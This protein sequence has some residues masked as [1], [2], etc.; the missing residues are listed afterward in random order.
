M[1]N[2]S[3]SRTTNLLG[4]FDLQFWGKTH[5]DLIDEKE[6]RGGFLSFSE[7]SFTVDAPVYDN[8][9][10]AAY[11]NTKGNYKS[12][13]TVPADDTLISLGTLTYQNDTLENDFASDARHGANFNLTLNNS[14]EGS[15]NSN[16][17]IHI[18]NNRNG[19]ENIRIGGKPGV[20]KRL[21]LRDPNR[22]PLPIF[23]D[24]VG[25][26]EI[27]ASEDTPLK[28]S[29]DVL[30]STTTQFQL[31]GRLFTTEDFPEPVQITSISE[32]T[33]IEGD[34][35]TNDTTLVFN[36]TAGASNKI[37]VFLDN[38]SIGTTT[39]DASGNWSY[40]YT[41]T[42]LLEGQYQVS[43][44]A[45]TMAKDTFVS[46][47]PKELTIDTTAPDI[48]ITSISEDTGVKGDFR[49]RDNTL[50]FNGTAEAGSE[51]ELFVDNKS[52]GTTTA[53]AQGDWSYDYTSFKFADGK[54]KLTA[55]A[56]DLAGNIGTKK[57]PIEIDT[58]APD[59]KITSI[60]EDTGVKGDFRTSDNTLIFNGTAEAGSKVE[61]FVDNKSIGTT[62]TNAQGDWSYDYTSFKFADGKYKLTATATD[63]ADNIGTTKQPKTLEIDTNFDITFDFLDPSIAS[64]NKLKNRIK[65][66]AAFWSGQDNKQSPIILKDIP[67]VKD[68]KL[69]IIDDL[70]IKVVV[71]SKNTNPGALAVTVGNSYKFRPQ[72]GSSI[73][74]LTGQP[75][76][77]FD[78]LPYY[79]EI[80]IPQS[81]L[82]DAEN[83]PYGLDTLKHEIG[84]ALGFNGKVFLKKGLLSARFGFYTKYEYFGL[85]KVEYA[86]SGFTG[87]NAVQQYHLMKGN[88][89]HNSVPLQDIEVDSK[90]KLSPPSSHW[91]EWIFPDNSEISTFTRWILGIPT[92]DDDLMSESTPP[93]YKAS[94]SK[95]TLGA[96]QDIGYQVDMTQASTNMEVFNQHGNITSPLVSQPY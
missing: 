41:K 62:T 87:T 27:G 78:H 59:I 17:Y 94:L 92:Y 77:S 9:R 93:A 96:F 40:D 18:I 33:G 53:N 82:N 70:H 57:Q 8:S 1:G 86:R 68:K 79:A 56:T 13:W 23:L 48:K 58:I 47:K 43:A 74:P 64:N 81:F 83:T 3:S 21:Q 66:A 90:T 71:D 51:V 15:F 88:K 42:V 46:S 6:Y 84:H 5:R 35:R 28:Y 32:D 22:R 25:A 16:F 49:T 67:D 10:D 50:I 52:I 11:E 95:V 38:T 80:S 24:Y 2:S 89:A 19:A 36:G 91:H 63:L 60:S 73:D 14:V 69:G 4:N 31:F 54:Y 26:R 12:A 85:K 45:S 72:H 55:T 30:D 37:E 39:A 7:D 20:P 34:F 44:I 61:L 75:L 76:S 65:E 29:F